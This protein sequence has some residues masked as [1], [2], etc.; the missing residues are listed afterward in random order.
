MP[1]LLVQVAGLTMELQFVTS[2][3]GGAG[4]GDGAGAGAGAGDSEA[5]RR[6]AALEQERTALLTDKKVGGSW[7]RGTSA[8]RAGIAARGCGTRME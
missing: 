3:G 1:A 7:D 5:A 6:L 4:A 2:A 8:D